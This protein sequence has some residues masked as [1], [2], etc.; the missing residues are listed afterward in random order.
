MKI[1]RNGESLE[2]VLMM[3]HPRSEE[4]EKAEVTPLGALGHVMTSSGSCSYCLGTILA[5]PRGF[6]LLC[7]CVYSDEF[8]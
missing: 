3:H 1:E 5:H 8:C 7:V 6:H 2:A 4:A